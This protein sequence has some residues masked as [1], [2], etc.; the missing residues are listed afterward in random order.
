MDSGLITTLLGVIIASIISQT[1][2]VWVKFGSVEKRLADNRAALEAKIDKTKCPFGEC[3]IF[4]RAK[5]EAVSER[6]VKD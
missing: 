1:I 2:A 4:E 5:T 6:S 3:P